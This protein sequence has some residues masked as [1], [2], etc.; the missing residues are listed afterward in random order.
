[1]STTTTSAVTFTP[2]FQ[3]GQSIITLTTTNFVKLQKE[4]YLS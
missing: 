2:T 1:M 4:N 3:L